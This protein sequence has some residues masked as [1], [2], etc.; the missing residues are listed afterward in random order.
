MIKN[1]MIPDNLVDHIIS[2]VFDPRGYDYIDYYEN[3]YNKSSEMKAICKELK[4][5]HDSELSISWLKPSSLQKKFIPLFWKSIKEG[6][7]KIYYH[8]GFYS[9]DDRFD[10]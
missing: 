2:L 10:V 4:R 8:T 9:I 1:K 6:N 5:F 3:K 7:P